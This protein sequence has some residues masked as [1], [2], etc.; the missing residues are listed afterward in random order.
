[1]AQGH[2]STV[3][4]QIIQEGIMSVCRLDGYGPTDGPENA[5]HATTGP[6]SYAARESGQ[7][8]EWLMVA[9]AGMNLVAVGW[10]PLQY[11]RVRA[12]RD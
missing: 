10:S 2:Q 8:C 11:E 3:K 7:D 6:T 4:D 9:D 5:Q 12:S 1:M